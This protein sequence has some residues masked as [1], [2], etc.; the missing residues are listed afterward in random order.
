[1]DPYRM[2]ATPAN[3]PATGKPFHAIVGSAGGPV[4]LPLPPGDAAGQGFEMEIYACF[5]RHLRDVPNSRVEIK[6]L[7][8]ITSTAGLIN[9][10]EALVAKTLVD[11]GLRGPRQAFPAA[12]LDFADRATLRGAW[13]PGGAPATVQALAD[14]WQRGGGDPFASL[15][16]SVAMTGGR[17]E[18]VR[19]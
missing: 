7:S 16:A 19:A 17:N 1:M 18:I 3:R 9:V 8:A 10:S 13:Q 2:P 14:Y 5:M 6:V 11:L 12:F 15:A 4:S